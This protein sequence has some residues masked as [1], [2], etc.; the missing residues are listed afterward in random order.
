MTV[1]A[2]GTVGFLAET[3]LVGTGL[4]LLRHQFLRRDFTTAAV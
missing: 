2:A 3:L 4:V 1:L